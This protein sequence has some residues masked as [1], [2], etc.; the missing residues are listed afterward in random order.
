MSKW[1]DKNLFDD[2]QKKKTEEKDQPSNNRSELLWENPKMGTTENAKIYEGRLLPDPD[3]SF[4]ERYYYHMWQAT[5]DSWYFVLCPK[6]EKFENFCPLCKA[7][8][9]LYATGSK[10]DKRQ[11]YNIKRKEKFAVNWFVVRD[12]RDDDRDEENKVTGKVK[13]YEF[14]SVV[15]KKIKTEITD[16]DEGYGMSIFDPGEDGR[17]FIIKVFATKPDKNKKQWPDYSAS[18]FSR[19][20]SALGD[21]EKIEEI[22]NSRVNIKEYINGMALSKNAVITI[23]KK[24][25]L[26]DIVED[27]CLKNGYVPDDEDSEEEKSEKKEEK[28]KKSESK[29]DTKTKKDEDDDPP[30]T[31]DE[32]D[33]GEETGEVEERSDDSDLD[34]DDLLAELDDL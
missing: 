34:D 26:W 25:F 33:D 6:T 4:Y 32:E 17:N 31:T 15:E 5:D 27:E 10:E 13:I 28:K 20:N 11:A 23:L 22:M 12:S 21:D 30:W 19:T 7:N 24:E 18:S 1:I 9:K 2:F 29:K 14:P 16:K 3:N 8:Q